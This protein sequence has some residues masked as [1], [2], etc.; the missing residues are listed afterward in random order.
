MAFE[1]FEVDEDSIVQYY[2][3]SNES[4]DYYD[5][6]WLRFRDLVQGDRTNG[7]R[8]DAVHTLVPRPKVG[9]WFQTTADLPSA[10]K[11]SLNSI[12]HVAYPEALYKQTAA[13]GTASWVLYLKWY[14]TKAEMDADLVP[15]AD[16]L[17]IVDKDPTTTNRG[18]Y[19][20]IGATTTGSWAAHAATPTWTLNGTNNRTGVRSNGTAFWEIPLSVGVYQS[21][22]S[23]ILRPQW[24]GNSNAELIRGAD[25]GSNVFRLYSQRGSSVNRLT[26]GGSNALA[27]P[28]EKTGFTTGAMVLMTAAFDHAVGG[29]ATVRKNFVQVRD[30]SVTE[31]VIADRSSGQYVALTGNS[32]ADGKDPYWLLGGGNASIFADFCEL[33]VWTNPKLLQNEKSRHDLWKADRIAY[34][35]VP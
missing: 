7:L 17:A 16:V 8:H 19:Y 9:A 32:V 1:A 5:W 13:Y 30:G 20:K 22:V 31:G 10:T 28:Q 15:G 25:A 11:F 21:T 35:P 24:L 2:R 12:A 26:L 33:A 27:S 14:A 29:A 6:H 4:D 34:Y 18:L 3:F 23:V